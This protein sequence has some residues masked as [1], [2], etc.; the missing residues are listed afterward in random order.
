MTTLYRGGTIYTPQDPQASALLEQDGTIAWLGGEQAAD[1][2]LAADDGVQVVDLDGALLAP[3]FV[4]AHLHT[5]ETGLLLTGVDLTR[6]R[7]VTEILDLVAA[8]AA[9]APAG[10]RVM[11]HGW[12]EQLLAEGRP[13]TR[14]ELDRAG[15]GREVYLCRMDVHSGLVSSALARASGADQH[16]GWTE[17]GRVEREA[18]HA[19]RDVTRRLAPAH[20]EHVQLAALR[21]AARVGIV[22]VHEMSAPHIAP[23]QDLL[24]LLELAAAHDVPQ[25]LP[26]RGELVGHEDQAR[27]LVQRFGGRLAGLAGDLNVDGSLGSRTAALR[28]DYLDAP[29]HRGHLYLEPEQIRDHLVACTRAGVQGGFHVIG[30]AGLAAAVEGIRQAA[31]V[32]GAQQLRAARHRLEHVELADEQAVRALAEHG[33]LA[34]VQ[35]VFDAMWGGEQQL[36]AQRLGAGRSLASNALGPMSAAGVALALG[37]DSPVTPLGPWEAVRA[38]AFHFRA[39]SRI[40]ARAAFSAHTR[41]GWR[42][43][44]SDREGVLRIGAPATFAIWRAGDLVVQ[45]P[46]DRV[47]AWSTDPRSGT[48]GLPDLTPGVPAPLCLRT[49]LAG[50]VLHD[51]SSSGSASS[52]AGRSL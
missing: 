18:H 4:D 46:D 16:D 47:Q 17:D 37:S 3:G 28:E 31:K 13:P 1:A 45:A 49:V 26:Y 15:G 40:S 2:L 23:E 6:T 20:R 25:V 9:T 7:S 19:V 52:A 10:M 41:G 35:P 8:A 42:A 48:P 43:G 11:G 27:E 24:G 36:Y 5:T 33:V 34:S 44:G 50:R 32:A 29:G 51:H 21:A 39:E 30:D 38:A 14:A 12:Q 22:A